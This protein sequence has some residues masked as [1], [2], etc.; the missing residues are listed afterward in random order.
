MKKIWN[1]IKNILRKTKFDNMLF[2]KGMRELEKILLSKSMDAFESVEKILDLI[3]ETM[4]KKFGHIKCVYKWINKA[5]TEI[6]SKL[7]EN[8]EFLRAEVKEK[9]SFIINKIIE[10]YNKNM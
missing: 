1:W 2:E 7:Q 8:K 5:L 3:D 6:N 10:W 9:I 4:L